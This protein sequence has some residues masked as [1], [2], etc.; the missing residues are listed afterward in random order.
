MEELLYRK[1]LKQPHLRDDDPYVVCNDANNNDRINEILNRQLTVVQGQLAQR[2]KRRREANFST[3]NIHDHDLRE[4]TLRQCLGV[5]K[6]RRANIVL[7]AIDQIGVEL[8]GDCATRCD[9]RM[10]LSK[11]T[12]PDPVRQ[13]F[14]FTSLR[15]QMYFTPVS[16]L[17]TIA[18]DVTL[19]KAERRLFDYKEWS[20][21]CK[22]NLRRYKDH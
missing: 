7:K 10:R 11:G 20:N 17:H 1:H 5:D 14:C 12:M 4:Q 6:Y 8:C 19:H 18:W 21:K 15:T 22:E 2:C 13:L 16:Q 9:G 3:S